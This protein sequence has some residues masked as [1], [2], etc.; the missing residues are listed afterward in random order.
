MTSQAITRHAPPLRDGKEA[1][2]DERGKQALDQISWA[3]GGLAFVKRADTARGL[4]CIYVPIS[5]V[6][7][8]FFA[9]TCTASLPCAPWK[10][11]KGEEV[12]N[13]AQPG[14]ICCEISLKISAELCLPLH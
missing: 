13:G 12:E 7:R 4:P 1:K 14:L 8:P 9:S 2:P 3:S 11:R 6:R 10:R 5:R